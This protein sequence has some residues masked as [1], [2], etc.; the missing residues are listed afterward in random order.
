VFGQSAS[1]SQLY[2]KQLPD[3]EAVQ[4]T[5]TS[6]GKA[7]PVFSPDGSRIAFTSSENNFAWATHIV[8]ANGGNVTELLPNASGLSWIDDGRVMFSENR[9]GIHMGI[10]SATIARA[11]VR[12]VY[13]PANE[14]GMAHRSAMSPDRKWVLLAEM[15]RGIWT[16]CRLVPADG[17]STGQ[18]VGPE[19][20]CTYAAWD[21][22]GR[23]MYFSSNAGGR[24]HIWRQRFPNGKPEQLTNGPT[25]E[26][27]LA[28]APDGKSLLTSAG[29]RLNT[30][31]LLDGAGDRELSEEGFA[32]LPQ[33]SK[34]G[35][36]VYF[37]VQTGAARGASFVG[38]LVALTL[39]TRVREDI[40][41]DQLVAHFD[42]SAD[43]RSIVFVSGRD[44][45]DKK[46]IWV[47][48]LDRSAA[49]RRVFDGKAERA[50]F[51]PAGNIYFVGN[52]GSTLF[53]HRLRAP[54]YVRERVSPDPV[55]H[56]FAISPTGNGWWSCRPTPKVTACARSPC[57]R[58]DC[59]LC[60]CV[61]SA[62]VV[63]VPPASTH[64]GCPGRAMGASC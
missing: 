19:G 5:N 29:V 38:H 55:F 54:D 40:L 28:I 58:A 50:F 27:G 10:R 53:L 25:E 57:P 46:G 36:R 61:P 13:W 30:I 51:D 8:G 33:A 44:E 45:P 35:A 15:D 37:I 59:R 43:D 47:A 22:R 48:P 4:L 23:W 3:G 34:D 56:L 12:D 17:S 42:L 64:R 11:D 49:P 20:S 7:T 39:S 16:P 63:V 32:L 1:I 14:M 9:K 21:P 18:Q 26:E 2:V 62:R 52:E 31:R 41:P 24:F 60:F 6:A